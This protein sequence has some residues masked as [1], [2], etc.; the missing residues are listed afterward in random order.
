MDPIGFA[1]ENYVAVGRWRE[2]DAAGFDIDP[3]GRIR[4]SRK[5]A[6]A[7]AAADAAAGADAGDSE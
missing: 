5:E 3:S 4:L 6:L 7:D 2:R 1:M